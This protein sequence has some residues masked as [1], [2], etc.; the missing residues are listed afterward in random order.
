MPGVDLGVD[1]GPD[2]ID[3]A[4]LDG[5]LARHHDPQRE[6]GILPHERAQRLRRGQRA[7]QIPRDVGEQRRP[8]TLA[9][10]VRP[11]D[12]A[13]ERR[14][15]DLAVELLATPDPAEQRR[16]ADPELLGELADVDALAGEPLAVRGLE[17][18]ECGDALACD[19]LVEHAREGRPPPFAG[20]RHGVQRTPRPA[21]VARPP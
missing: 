9:H 16:A 19:R 2:R 17:G 5:T 7:E 14:G 18:V 12:R 4:A 1:Q 13:C 3:A 15:D 21:S 20:I 8:A 10:P 6:F 11:L